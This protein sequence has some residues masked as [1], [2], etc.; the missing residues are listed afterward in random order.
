M[1]NEVEEIQA[2]LSG[3]AAR[4]EALRADL[5]SATEAARDATDKIIGGAS[6]TAA[7]IATGGAKAVLQ[8][9]LAAIVARIEPLQNKLDAAKEAAEEAERAAN[10]E[11]ALKAYD[12][13]T[14][15]TAQL[16]REFATGNAPAIQA[17]DAARSAV[18]GAEKAMIRAGERPHY[19]ASAL[20]YARPCG[21]VRPF[22]KHLADYLSGATYVTLSTPPAPPH[23]QDLSRAGID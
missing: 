5:A 22:L 16:I 9:A 15:S 23:A 3:L 19:Q 1:K 20:E 8:D 11:A 10:Y 6:A 4:R 18:Y 21:D 2:E 12:A 17:L 7:L 14:I 13:A